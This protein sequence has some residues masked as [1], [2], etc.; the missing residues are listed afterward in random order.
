[1]SK[2]VLGDN[3]CRAANLA[4]KT[5]DPY[6]NRKSKG[7]KS[8]LANKIKEILGKSELSPDDTTGDVGRVLQQLEPIGVECAC[9]SSW[10]KD[11]LYHDIKCRQKK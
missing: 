10:L 8:S 5:D 7:W 3:I 1:M 6:F 11:N 4:I 2:P 9:G